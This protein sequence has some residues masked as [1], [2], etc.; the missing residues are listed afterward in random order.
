[1]LTNLTDNYKYFICFTSQTYQM[2]S[3]DYRLKPSDLIDQSDLV[4][5]TPHYL[6]NINTDLFRIYKSCGVLSEWLVGS[7]V[8]LK[9][10]EIKRQC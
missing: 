2:L 5:V 1:M 7:T 8:F 6:T 9:Q 10:A 3:C 4:P